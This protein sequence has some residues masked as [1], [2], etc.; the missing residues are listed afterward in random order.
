[1]PP[2]TNTDRRPI[3]PRPVR[4]EDLPSVG[5]LL[6]D[7]FRRARGVFDQSQLTDFP[8]VYAPENLARNRLIAEDG[9]VVS[10]AGLW[11]RELI[12]FERRFKAAIIVSVVTHPRYRRRG[13][14]ASLMRSLQDQLHEE[15]YDL[16]ILW[17]AVPDF[18]RK[19]G[20]QL[21]TP[22]GAIVDLGAQCA[23]RIPGAGHECL[24]LDPSRHLD[25]LL[26]L[27]DRNPVRLARD[28]G[29][30]KRLFTLP[31]VPVWVAT[32]GGSVVAYVA[33]GQAINKRGITE[34]GGDLAGITAL[35]RHV[36]QSLPPAATVPLLVFHTR[37]DLAAW[38]AALRL[39]TRPLLSSKGENHEMLYL[40]RPDRTP[41]HLFGGLFAWGL[42]HA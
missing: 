14:A 26:E 36:V 20:W 35:L 22:R 18:Y 31:K 39:P 2:G 9:L 40:V 19:L 4:V 7:V 37:P 8:L 32:R 38:A 27:Y 23:E 1:M 6:D 5:Q 10:H 11:P 28:R 42:D 29:A 21:V 17:T 33:H 25:P 15:A 41:L 24:P 34:Y 3:G 30:A 12:Y 13:Y 16:A